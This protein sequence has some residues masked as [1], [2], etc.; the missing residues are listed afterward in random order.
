MS[1]LDVLMCDSFNLQIKL[2]HIYI[3]NTILRN[4]FAVIAGV[5]LG[6][7]LNMS[8]IIGGSKVFP[9]SE[10]FDPMNAMN[11]DLKYFIFPFLA[12]ALGTLAGAFIAAKIASTH[13]KTFALIIGAFFLIGG[14]MMVFML[15]APIWFVV[16]DLVVAYI[17]MGWLGWRISR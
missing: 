16:L 17:P 12:H 6:S 11:W 15:P 13:K 1:G 9:L 10:S 5:I 8:F 2:H 4:I 7:V 14:T 3:M